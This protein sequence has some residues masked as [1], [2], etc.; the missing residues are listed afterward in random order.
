ML[1]SLHSVLCLLFPFTL[2]YLDCLQYVALFPSRE[3]DTLKTDVALPSPIT[4]Q[5]DGCPHFFVFQYNY[6]FFLKLIVT[7]GSSVIYVCKYETCP[8]TP[9]A[10]SR[11]TG[12]CGV[13]G[14]WDICP[15]FILV[16]I[17]S[18]FCNG[19]ILAAKINRETVRLTDIQAGGQAKCDIRNKQ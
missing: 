3:F 8:Q 4:S 2:F 17:K 7:C 16:S 12:Y 6:F 18:A 13:F 1:R 5:L 9:V 15:R 10:V 11:N 19:R 14:Q